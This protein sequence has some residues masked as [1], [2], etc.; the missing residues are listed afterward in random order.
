MVKKTANPILA[1]SKFAWL[2]ELFLDCCTP[3]NIIISHVDRAMS[4]LYQEDN[5]SQ[6]D[7][8]SIISA[9][10]EQ[11]TKSIL[12]VFSPEKLHYYREEMSEKENEGYIVSLIDMA[13]LIFEHL[14][15][16]RVSS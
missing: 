6:E 8:D 4:T 13:G 2:Y 3:L 15:F 10:K 16:G 12:S 11:M 14:V 1:T 7:I 9:A 5:W